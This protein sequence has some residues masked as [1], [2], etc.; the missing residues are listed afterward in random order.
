MKDF[1]QSVGK[2]YLL[3]QINQKWS[4]VLQMKQR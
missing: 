2:K 1:D 4:D 3:A